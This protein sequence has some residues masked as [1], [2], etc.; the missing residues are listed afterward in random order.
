MVRCDKV[1]S[2]GEPGCVIS[3]YV[4]T[5]H[6]NTVAHP[7]AAVHAWVVQ[8]K[9]KVKGL[10]KTRDNPLHYVAPTDR[11]KNKYNRDKSRNAMCTRYQGPKD[12]STGWVARKT[13][14]PHPKTALHHPAPA[15]DEVN[16]DEFPFASTYESAGMT[17][18]D[19]GKNATKNGGADCMQ[20]AA[21]R[22]DDGSDHFIDDTRYDAPSFTEQCG[23]ASISGRHNQGSMVEPFPKFARE[24]RLLDEDAYMLNPG[25]DWFK[26]CDT[27]K[28]TLVCTMTKP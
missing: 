16:C 1:K 3:E 27:S 8:N 21:V 12:T 14:L 13:F 10:G 11:N 28:S 2:Y 26:G 5:Y 24:M 22:A 6:F 20:L 19:G 18:A 23:R 15:F 9:S 17:A 4:P 25:N 7:Q